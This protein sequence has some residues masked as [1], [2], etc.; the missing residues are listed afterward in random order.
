MG[1]GTKISWCTDTINFWS[2]CTKVSAGCAKC[3]AEALGTRFETLGKWGHGAPRVWHERNV[4]LLRQ[5]NKKPLVCS[6]C[7]PIRQ[8]VEV[9]KDGAC[10]NCGSKE[11]LM[12]REIFCLSLGDFLDPE[13]D[14]MWLLRML[15]VI[16]DMDQCRFL[17]LTKR[18]ELFEE[19][20]KAAV[21]C[22]SPSGQKWFAWIWKWIEGEPGHIP[23]HIAIGTSIEDRTCIERAYALTKIP[24]HKRFISFEPLLEKIDC[25][26]WYHNVG[27][28][29]NTPVP[30]WVIIGG[31]SGLNARPCNAEWIADMAL[32]AQNAGIPVWVKQ[33]GANSNLRYAQKWNLKDKKGADITEWPHYLQI[34]QRMNWN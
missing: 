12:R 25:A 27:D 1:R 6:V 14:P 10:V 8:K 9:T 19:R 29:Q 11:H 16:M 7:N 2:G 3:Y 15:E 21:N 31:E 20:L 32:Q 5:L 34:Q 30:D 22:I 26:M 13:V 18:P 4:R 17:L 33:M 24:A 23:E 28:W